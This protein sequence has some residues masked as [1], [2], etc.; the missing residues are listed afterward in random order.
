MYVSV[1]RIFGESWLS[2]HILP[3]NQGPF[4]V[5]SLVNKVISEWTQMK[6]G[7]GGGEFY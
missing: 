6:T 4:W 2:H 3:G 7:Q 5:L 1:T